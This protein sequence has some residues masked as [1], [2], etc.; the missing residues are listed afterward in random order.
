[1]E[2]WVMAVLI[3]AGIYA[4]AIISFYVSARTWKHQ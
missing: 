3:V 4:A 2:D 1:M